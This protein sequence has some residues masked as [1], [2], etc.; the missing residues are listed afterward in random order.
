MVRDVKV[1]LG[2][3]L[4]KDDEAKKLLQLNFSE[5]VKVKAGLACQDGFRTIPDIDTLRSVFKQSWT[6]T[7]SESTGI[8]SNESWDIFQHHQAGFE[9]KVT[10][11]WSPKRHSETVMLQFSWFPK[12]ESLNF[13]TSRV[14][15]RGRSLCRWADWVSGATSCSAGYGLAAM[16]G[17]GRPARFITWPASSFRYFQIPNPCNP[18]PRNEL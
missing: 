6:T 9:L 2:L 10:I 11:L 1:H 5:Q 18:N 3:T 13:T 4:G 15:Q 7:A 14:I 8:W 16:T 12:L 17:Q